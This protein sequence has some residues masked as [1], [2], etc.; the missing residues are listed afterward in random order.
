MT[1]MQK[2]AWFNLT[3]IGITLVVIGA[4]YPLMGHRALGGLGCLGLLGLQPFF[5][6]R[7][8]AG[9]VVMDERDALIQQRSWIIAYALFWVVFVIGAVVLSAMVYGQ[10]GSI[11]VSVVQMSVVWGMM[12]VYTA[13]S[14]AILVQYTGG[15]SDAGH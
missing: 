1:A 9:P 3:V 12:F 15:A 13:A 14:I 4:L 11:P 5:F 8:G 2:F 6:F 7:R 10:D